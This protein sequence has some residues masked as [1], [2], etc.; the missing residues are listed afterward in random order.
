MKIDLT[1]KQYECLIKALEAGSSVYGILGDDVSEEHKPQSE[2]IQELRDYFLSIA[3]EF[4][5]DHITEKFMGKLIMNEEYGEILDE[6]IEDYNNNV[7]WHELETRLGK[8]DFE[9]TITEAEKRQIEENNGWYPDRIHEIYEN[10]GKEFEDNGIE[11]L[12]VIKD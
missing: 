5:M 2:E 9:R 7:F 8:R 11:N 3:H 10:W 6:V 12:G 1:K 4:K